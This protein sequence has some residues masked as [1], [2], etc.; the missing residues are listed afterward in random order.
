MYAN[1][2]SLLIKM[3][4][5]IYKTNILII[6]PA[7]N[8]RL[9]TDYGGILTIEKFRESFNKIEYEPHGI[10]HQKFIGRIFEENIKF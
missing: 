10:I 4:N 3:Y 1:S 8:W 6:E 2:E 7:S 9:L 5:D